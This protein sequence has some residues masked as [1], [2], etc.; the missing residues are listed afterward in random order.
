MPLNETP[1]RWIDDFALR[2]VGET[3]WVFGKGPGLENF[4]FTSAGAL[5]ICINEAL[6]LVPAATYFFAHDERPIEHVAPTWPEDC[7]AISEPKRAIFAAESGIPVAR[8]AAYHKRQ[9]NDALLHC[10]SEQVAQ[11]RGLYGH[12]GTIHSA[13][14]FC[15]LIGVVKVILVGC[16]G[17][18]GY[19]S[20]LSMSIPVG[21][22]GHAV[23]RRDCEIML[24]S[25]NLP[26]IFYEH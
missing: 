2:H 14:H 7:W 26:Y 11:Q 20:S 9:R 17:S 21:G 10:D 8:I 5:R 18:G 6:L 22:G 23:I 4:D 24:Q 25:L 19:A 3:A 15:F 1:L 16:E 12:S 13:L